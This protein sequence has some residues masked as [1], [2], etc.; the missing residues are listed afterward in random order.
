M[1]IRQARDQGQRLDIAKCA[2]EFA[3]YTKKRF[4]RIE[5]GLTS[6]QTHQ[7]SHL[8]RVFKS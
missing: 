4:I 8:G 5:Q 3:K 7:M 2:M 1:N 6:H